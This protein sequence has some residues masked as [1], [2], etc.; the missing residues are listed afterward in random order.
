MHHPPF[1]K[2]KHNLHLVT[3]LLDPSSLQMCADQR[4]GELVFCPPGGVNLRVVFSPGPILL[5][6][7]TS[8]YLPHIQQSVVSS[9][10]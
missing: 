5:D 1:N 7:R 8:K 10:N 9:Q 2:D 3:T 4:G 6:E